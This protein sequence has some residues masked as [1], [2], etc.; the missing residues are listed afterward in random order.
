MLLDAVTQLGAPQFAVKGAE[1]SG[2]RWTDI[3]KMV[4]ERAMLRRTMFLALCRAEENRDAPGANILPSSAAGSESLPRDRHAQ[5]GR[6]EA[7]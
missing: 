7:R 4:P 1:K 5:K 2:V 3:A 6:G